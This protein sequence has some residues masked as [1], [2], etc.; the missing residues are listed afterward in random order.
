MNY[1]IAMDRYG[2]Y[3]L[4][5]H[6]VKGQKWGVR[7][8]QNEDGSL[9]PAGIQRYRMNGATNGLNRLAGDIAETKYKRALASV[10]R[11]KA[12]DAGKDDKAKKLDKLIASL[13]KSIADGEKNTDYIIKDLKS[14]GVRVSSVP[15][16]R[17]AGQGRMMAAAIVAG[18]FGVVPVAALDAY[19]ATKYGQEAGGI[20]DSRKY[21][22][23]G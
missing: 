2:N 14:N 8:Y 1:Y 3:D 5:H 21:K 13:D 23:R 18:P 10:K 12:L 9:T 19:R 16:K 17:Y 6:G 7:K 11:E 15:A 22:A 4:A 20:I